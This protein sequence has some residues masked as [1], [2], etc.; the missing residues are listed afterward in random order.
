MGHQ[1]GI[2]RDAEKIRQCSNGLAAAVHVGGRNQKTNVVALMAE[3]CR[4]AE[5]LAISRQV[6]ALGAGN[7]FYEK[8][9]C[10]MPGLFVF[11]AGVTQADDQ[12][13]GGHVRGSSLELWVT[14]LGA[15]TR[16]TPACRV[17]YSAAPSAASGATRGA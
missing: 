15:V 7:A 12:L 13:D 11:G 1:D 2:W 10:V 6:D 16:S 4:Q 8:S 17:D 9:P 5:I 3:F 14:A